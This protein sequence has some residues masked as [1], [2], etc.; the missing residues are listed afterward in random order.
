MDMETKKDIVKRCVTLGMD[1]YSSMIVAEMTDVEIAQLEEDED[2]KRRMMVHQKIHEKDLLE[3][4]NTC[5]SANVRYGNSTEV[6]WLLSKLNPKRFGNGAGPEKEK[7]LQPIE[8]VGP[9]EEDGQ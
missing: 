2:F 8:F 1:L 6:R 7:K 4:I 5:I 3:H 9:G